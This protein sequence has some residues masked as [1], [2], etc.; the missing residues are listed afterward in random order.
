MD[1]NLIR[2][3]R[4]QALRL[5]RHAADADDLLQ[6]TLLASLRAGRDEPAWL[7]GVLKKQAAMQARGEARR[8]RRE[9]AVAGDAEIVGMSEPQG[10]IP[11]F[12]LD[13]LPR[14]ARQVAVLV[15][16]GLSADE[17]RWLLDLTPM[18][19]RQRLTSIR[20]HLRQLPVELECPGPPPRT[21][22]LQFGLVRRALRTAMRDAA[23]LGSHDP[24]GHLLLI[25]RAHVSVPGGN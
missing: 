22:E 8:R 21:V 5:T 12:A 6:E 17:I 3:L 13:T 7:A 24:D 23:V 4:A 19:F 14:A 11:A 18:A 2:D 16:H 15:L 25:G 9:Q 10:T 1:A 20:K